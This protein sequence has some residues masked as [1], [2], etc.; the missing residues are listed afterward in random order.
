MSVRIF[1]TSLE[2]GKSNIIIIK[3]IFIAFPH[4]ESK[5]KLYLHRRSA[6]TAQPIADVTPCPN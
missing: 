1:F 5:G 3:H 4:E 6:L 2:N